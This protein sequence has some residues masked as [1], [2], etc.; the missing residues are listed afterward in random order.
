[1]R[2]SFEC[3]VSSTGLVQTFA[4]FVETAL[5]QVRSLWI[6]KHEMRYG[7]V[8]KPECVRYT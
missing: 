5:T 2:V 1:M 6:L 7:H 4:L 3:E 8:K